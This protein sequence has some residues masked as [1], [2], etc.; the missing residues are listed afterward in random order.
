MG[1]ILMLCGP[2]GENEDLA[3]ALLHSKDNE[4]KMPRHEPGITLSAKLADEWTL[5]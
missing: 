5:A 4:T 2:P 3:N 1:V